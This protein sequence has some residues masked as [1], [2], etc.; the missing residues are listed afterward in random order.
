MPARPASR[1]R[2]LTR[3]E[4]AAFLWAARRTPHV[5]RFFLIGWYTGSRKDVILNT[6][7][8]LID[9]KG[10]ILHR[11][12]PGA[13]QRKKRAPPHHFYPT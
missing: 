12:P 5:A 1:I 9:T 11:K 7:W 2:W 4:A 13:V 8:S 3:S 6:K 10:R